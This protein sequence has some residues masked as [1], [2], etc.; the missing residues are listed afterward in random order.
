V[1]E[2]VRQAGA[3]PSAEP[4]RLADELRAMGLM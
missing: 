4:V 3:A 2:R 1:A